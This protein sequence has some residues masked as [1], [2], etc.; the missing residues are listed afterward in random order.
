[1]IGSIRRC[2]VLSQF[3]RIA[4]IDRV[5]RLLVGQLFALGLILPRILAI[6]VTLV[7]ADLILDGIG[8]RKFVV[9]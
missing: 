1:M 7:P 4:G 5:T 2:L 8:T 9:F 3:C 6:I